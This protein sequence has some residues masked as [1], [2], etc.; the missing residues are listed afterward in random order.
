MAVE[1][2]VH[3]NQLFDVYGPLLTERQRELFRA[4]YQE[5]LSLGEIAEELGITRQ[6]VYDILRRSERTLEELEDKLGL[7]AR[8]RRQDRLWA[9]MQAD[10]RR[11]QEKLTSRGM[12]KSPDLSLAREILDA[13]NRWTEAWRRELD[14]ALEIAGEPPEAGGEGAQGPDPAP[15]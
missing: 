9:A 3:L 4:Y 15:R 10:A 2:T 7:L 13:L 5:D 14:D 1:R 6:G 11:L 12:G 8:Q